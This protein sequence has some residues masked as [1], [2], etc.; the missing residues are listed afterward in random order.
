MSEKYTMDTSD[1]KSFFQQAT[2]WLI[3]LVLSI[4][5]IYFGNLVLLLQ[6]PDHVFSSVDFV[7]TNLQANLMIGA[8]VKYIT[9]R[10]FDIY[11]RYTAGK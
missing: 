10:F 9:D 2:V 8:I 5:A 11:R 7:P 1:W 4:G 6:A 3:P